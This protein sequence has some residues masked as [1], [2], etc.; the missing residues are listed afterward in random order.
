MKD[1]KT[2]AQYTPR[3]MRASER[4]SLCKYYQ[5]INASDGDCDKVAGI[6]QAVGWC[7]HF[8]GKS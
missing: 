2:Q 5:R 3:A 7:R 6:V 8:A 1:T 4:C